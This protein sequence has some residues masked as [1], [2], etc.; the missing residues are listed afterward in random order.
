MF[1][2]LITVS[3]C[4]LVTKR[5]LVCSV[6]DIS[7]F[8]GLVWGNDQKASLKDQVHSE[9]LFVYCVISALFSPSSRN[10]TSNRKDSM[11]YISSACI[12]ILLNIKFFSKEFK[13]LYTD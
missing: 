12:K 2:K 4:V 8:L 5:T 13:M 7:K 9:F 11:R 10:R 1:D 3:Q 6:S